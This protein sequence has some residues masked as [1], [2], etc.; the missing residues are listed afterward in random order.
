MSGQVAAATAAKR[1]VYAVD[2]DK[3]LDIFDVQSVDADAIRVRTPLLFEI[4]EELSLR[5]VDGGSSRDVFVR[6]RAHA[7]PADARVTE[8]EILPP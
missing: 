2:G 7:G 4:G 6:V 5:I 1:V 8:L 3:T